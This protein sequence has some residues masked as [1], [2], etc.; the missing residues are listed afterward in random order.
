M[1]SVSLLA[2]RVLMSNLRYRSRSLKW[3]SGIVAA[4]IGPRP[5]TD[6]SSLNCSMWNLF[7]PASKNKPMKA[8]NSIIVEGV[9]C[10]LL[11]EC[12]SFHSVYARFS[13]SVCFPHYDIKHFCCNIELKW[14]FSLSVQFLPVWLQMVGFMLYLAVHAC[15]VQEGWHSKPEAKM[16]VLLLSQ[17]LQSKHLRA[18][19]EFFLP[20]LHSQT[21]LVLNTHTPLHHL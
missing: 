10:F 20:P 5:C 1:L 18:V 13:F 3:F 15:R 21:Y 19:P 14:S 12:A 7:N 9:H 11:S 4:E 17:L 8:F 2:D 6:H 16:Y